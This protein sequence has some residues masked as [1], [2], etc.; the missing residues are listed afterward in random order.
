MIWNQGRNDKWI[1][2]WYPETMGYFK[3]GDT[4][5][6]CALAGAFTLREAYHRSMMGPISLNHLYHM[7]GRIAPSG[8]D[9]DVHISNDVDDGT[10][11]ASGTVGWATYPER[12]SAVGVDWWVHQE[13]GYRSSLL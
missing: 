6:H 2:V 12:L 4:P 11:D 5:Y 9:K 7:S 10:T 3:C 13:S 1:A 8:D